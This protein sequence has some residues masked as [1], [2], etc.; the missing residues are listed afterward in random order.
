M[1]T[2]PTLPKYLNGGIGW[3]QFQLNPYFCDPDG[4]LAIAW[5]DS[6]RTM[7]GPFKAVGDCW[8]GP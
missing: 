3:A 1:F 5:A 7:S 2:G 8:A 6:P 4:E